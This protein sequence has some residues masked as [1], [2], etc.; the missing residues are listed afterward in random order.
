MHRNCTKIVAH[1]RSGKLALASPDF[2][3]RESSSTPLDQPCA[4]TAAAPACDFC[5]RCRGA[6]T[7][8]HAQRL[9][10]DS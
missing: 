5:Q 9:Q 1:P 4:L 7:A 6:D 2:R 8:A 10:A 3:V